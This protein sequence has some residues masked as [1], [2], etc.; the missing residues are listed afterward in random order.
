MYEVNPIWEFVVTHEY[1]G[2]GFGL[3]TTIFM[4][5]VIWIGQQRSEVQKEE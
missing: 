2:L 5:A 1:F 4:I 3:V